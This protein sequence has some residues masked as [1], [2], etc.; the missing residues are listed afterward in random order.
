VAGGACQSTCNSNQQA[1]SEACALSSELCCKI[2][3]GSS[4]IWIWILAALILVTLIG[5]VSR[6]KLSVLWFRVKSK[7]K[8]G[9]NKAPSGPGYP[10]PPFP[11]RP[12]MTFQR[13]PYPPQPQRQKPSEINDVLKKLREIGK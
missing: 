3:Q 7:F 13:R 9:G 1:S 10:R 8:K 12:P 2:K 6:K 5:I 11:P 4:T